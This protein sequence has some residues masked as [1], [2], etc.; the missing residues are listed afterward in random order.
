MSD[1]PHI[2]PATQRG[3]KK[4]EKLKTLCGVDHPELATK[5]FGDSLVEDS[6]HLD[7]DDNKLSK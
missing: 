4:Y 1:D 7:S 2:K 5:L 6:K 3:R